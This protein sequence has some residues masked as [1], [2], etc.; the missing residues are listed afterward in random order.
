MKNWLSI[1]RYSLCRFRYRKQV[2][3]CTTIV[4]SSHQLY[5][6]N[7]QPYQHTV[8]SIPNN[9]D[10][11]VSKI[12]KFYPIVDP[13]KLSTGLKIQDTIKLSTTLPN[14]LSPNSSVRNTSSSS[15]LNNTINNQKTTIQKQTKHNNV[16]S[17]ILYIYIP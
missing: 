12:T 16:D 15:P 1:V 10:Y 11:V 17:T 2:A 9:N 4:V 5:N 7:T 3:K 6:N 8:R 14:P 13:N